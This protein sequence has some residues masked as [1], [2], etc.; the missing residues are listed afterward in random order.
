M[1]ITR[2]QLRQLIKEEFIEEA[3]T[4]TDID[5][6]T[7]SRAI[8]DDAG[9]PTVSAH[10]K[11]TGGEIK[12]FMT[13]PVIG[14]R[15]NIG[16]D[17]QTMKRQRKDDDTGELEGG[18]RSDDPDAHNKSYLFIVDPE[19]RSKSKDGTQLE[20]IAAWQNREYHEGQD[21]FAPEGTDIPAYIDGF[22][23]YAGLEAGDGG[24]VVT[25]ASAM[26]IPDQ[27]TDTQW[28]YPMGTEFVRYAHLNSYAV[29]RGQEIKYGT[30]I[31]TVGDTGSA[32]GT[33]PH[34][35]LSVSRADKNGKFNWSK[36]YHRDPYDLFNQSG[37]LTDK[38]DLYLSESDIYQHVRHII[39]EELE[40]IDT[41]V[42][43][44]DGIENPK[45]A[46][47]IPDSQADQIMER[48]NKLAGL[49]K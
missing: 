25:L 32:Q 35:H 18:V 26:P 28:R 3:G 33:A 31:G 46:V 21:I 40:K 41:Y 9:Q 10:D 30:I 43:D 34:I 4:D 2:R 15:F 47:I 13:D 37:W 44:G 27:I 49:I 1:K 5:T 42:P 6:D 38:K 12:K 8:D 48:W 16:Y 23:D 39:N 24:N 7:D 19:D 11:L 22:V 36:E 20:P 29:E 14:K 17:S 45:W